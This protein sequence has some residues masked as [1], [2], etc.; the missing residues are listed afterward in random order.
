MAIRKKLGY[1]SESLIICSI[2]GTS[3]GKELLELAANAYPI[4]KEKMPGR[5]STSMV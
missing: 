2:G 1:D 5:S 3:I 4:V